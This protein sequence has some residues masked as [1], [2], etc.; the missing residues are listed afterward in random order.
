MLY[1]WRIMSTKKI[2]KCVIL[3]STTGCFL[4]ERGRITPL[5]CKKGPNNKLNGLASV[6]QQTL[7]KPTMIKFLFVSCCLHPSPPRSLPVALEQKIWASGDGSQ[8]RP[9]TWLLPLLLV[10]D[11]DGIPPRSGQPR[12]D[13]KP[14]PLYQGCWSGCWCWLSGEFSAFTE[15][16]R[17]L[18][19][20]PMHKVERNWECRRPWT[21]HT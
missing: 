10:V 7:A 1:P 17:W 15:T 21:Q 6:S 13:G 3:K 14:R 18:P 4:T 9:R 5:W 11:D 20:L 12:E 16:R 8:P 19:L 2:R